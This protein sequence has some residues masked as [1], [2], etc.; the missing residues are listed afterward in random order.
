M[1]NYPT[2][3]LVINIQ[4]GMAYQVDR[5]N[6][7]AYDDDYFAKTA[8]KTL[9]GPINKFRVGIVDKHV[10][11]G[12]VLDYGCGDCAFIESRPNTYGYDVCEKTIRKLKDMG[13]YHEFQSEGLSGFCGITFFDSLEHMPEP[14]Y[15]LQKVEDQIVII[16]VPIIKDIKL[17]RQWKHYRPNEHFWNW[18]NNGF[19]EWMDRQGFECIDYSEGEI[20]AGREDTPTFV[21]RRK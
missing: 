13:K 14:K 5:T 19:I 8:G 16:T 10:N 15:V 6:P 17:I 11:V 18:T 21:F 12:K 2:E 1:M 4:K 7:V 3:D 9:K 20:E